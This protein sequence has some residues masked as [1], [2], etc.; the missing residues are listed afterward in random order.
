LLPEFTISRPADVDGVL[1]ELSADVVPYAGGTE[2]LLAMKM[3]LLVP[4]GLVDL[5]RIPAL[6]DISVTESA[7]VIGAG[8][9]HDDVARHEQIRTHAPLLVQVEEHVGNA[10]VRSQGT[11]GG[12]LCFAEPRS[13]LLALLAA[14]DATVLLRAVRGE[15]TLTMAEFVLGPYWTERAEDELMVHVAIPR[16][17]PTGAYVKLQVTER[18][19]VGVAAVRTVT[20][21]CRVVVGSVTE[22]PLVVT[23][24]SWD[25]IDTDAIVAQLEPVSDIAGSAEYKKHIT[26]VYVRRAI[27]RARDGAA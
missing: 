4:T 15:R 1:R 18:P 10:R 26:G 16:P 8:A 20:G 21:E 6:R 22:V 19:T 3:G 17:C 14:F 27:A 7:I 13:D 9:T 12:N 5:K 2:L 25:D 23:G 11:V 24:A